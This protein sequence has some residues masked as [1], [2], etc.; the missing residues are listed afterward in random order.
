MIFE[1]ITD[2][3]IPPMA[4]RMLDEDN[5][6]IIEVMTAIG[7]IEVDEPEFRSGLMYRLQYR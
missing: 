1:V 5:N 2:G 6:M 4:T 7:W 3:V